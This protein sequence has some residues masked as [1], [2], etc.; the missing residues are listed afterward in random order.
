MARTPKTVSD[1]HEPAALRGTRS[2]RGMALAVVS[3]G[4]L[5]LWICSCGGTATRVGKSSRSVLPVED[6]TTVIEHITTTSRV[7]GP[8]DPDDFPR[9]VNFGHAAGALVSRRI[10]AL[11][12]RYYSAAVALDGRV[13]CSMLYSLVVTTIADGDAS[14]E[15]LQ[16]GRCAPAMSRLFRQRHHR[17]VV[18]RDSLVIARVRIE[19]LN[20]RVML[21]FANQPEARELDLRLVKGHRWRIAHALDSPLS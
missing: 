18:E 8:L 3:A 10:S 16:R 17:F 6:R 19:G 5:C 7:L 1:L 15:G 2:P 20:C 13:A 21:R 9:V 4:M 11:I 12:R 14:A